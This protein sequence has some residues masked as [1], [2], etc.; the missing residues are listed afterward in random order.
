MHSESP[1]W[2]KMT[3]DKIN[4]EFVESNSTYFQDVDIAR[5]HLI[6]TLFSRGIEQARDS[7][8]S[9][10]IGGGDKTFVVAL[11]AVSCSFRKEVNPFEK[12]EM[13]TRVLSWDQ[14]WVYIVTHFVRKGAVSPR[15]LTL[16][17]GQKNP[18]GGQSFVDNKEDAVIASALSKVVFKKGRLTIPPEV[19]LQVSGLLPPRPSD[20]ALT[21]RHIRPVPIQKNFA[22]EIYNVPFRFF[23]RL[24]VVWEATRNALVPESEQ[25]CRPAKRQSYDESEEKEI[26]WTWDMVEQERRRGLE[27]A[28]KLH[29]LDG[30]VGEF[31]AEADAL[32]RH[33]DLWWF[34][35][36]TY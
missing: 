4:D 14:K 10:S 2:E 17:P 36:L 6:C 24:D 15:K 13:W 1:R 23:E 27:T 33:S 32:G 5:A 12:Y 28:V 30:L 20:L 25:K 19:M 11:G 8:G 18:N 29:G 9:D 21:P 35:G 16:Y 34:L 31:T 26:E 3:D 22:T 7:K